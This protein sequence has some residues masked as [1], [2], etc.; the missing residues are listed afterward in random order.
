MKPYIA[1]DLRDMNR[2][3]I[4]QLLSENGDTPRRS[5]PGGRASPRPR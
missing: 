2:R 4:F 5:L 1:S 3:T